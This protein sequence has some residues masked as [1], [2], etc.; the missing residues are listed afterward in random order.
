MYVMKYLFI[1]T[2]SFHIFAWLSY[3]Y[4]SH[5]MYEM[6]DSY[7]I[8]REHYKSKCEILKNNQSDTE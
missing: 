5:W 1:I 7:Y 3:L 2:I 4:M 6:R 8:I